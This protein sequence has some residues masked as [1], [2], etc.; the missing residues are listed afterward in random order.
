M[1]AADGRGDIHHGF[2]VEKLVIGRTLGSWPS[3]ALAQAGR[4]DS[5]SCAQR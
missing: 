2:N 3:I 1:Q 5:S 4:R